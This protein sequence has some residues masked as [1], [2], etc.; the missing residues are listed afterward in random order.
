MLPDSA[1]RLKYVREK[2]GITQLTLSESIGVPEYKIKTIESGN[3]KI[4]VKIALEIEKIYKFDFKWILTGLGEP[5]NIDKDIKE[6]D[7]A[8]IFLNLKDARNKAGLTQPELSKKTGISTRSIAEYEKYPKKVTFEKMQ[9]IAL[10]CGI[11]LNQILGLDPESPTTKPAP[12]AKQ[13]PLNP[14]LLKEILETIDVV[15]DKTKKKITH[16]QKAQLTIVLYDFFLETKSKV[17]KEKVTQYL[18]LIS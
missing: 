6:K 2:L 8:S 13:D 11:N 9:Y 15:L 3:T 16:K 12:T 18:K 17:S 1:K 10:A 5:K 7:K 4:S 14:D